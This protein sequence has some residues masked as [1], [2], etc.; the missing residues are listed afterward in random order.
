MKELN[1]IFPGWGSVKE[2]YLDNLKLKGKII[3]IQ[4]YDLEKIWKNLENTIKSYDIINI[5]GWSLG[6]LIAL[7]LLLGK[8][9]K[10]EEKKEIKKDIKNK[11]NRLILFAPTLKFTETTPKVIVK[12]MKKNLLR[13]KE[14]TLKEFIK[15]N[16]Y[17]ENNFLEYWEKYKE[18]IINLDTE[19]LL[20][21]LDILENW[22]LNYI[23]INY[24]I[25]L[26]IFL[27]IEDSI[28]INNNSNKVI[29]KFKKVKVH[30]LSNC[31]HNIIFEKK[32]EIIKILGVMYD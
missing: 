10:E 9:E 29:E 12:R 22:D 15:L 17:S 26:T 27:G 2:F 4:D 21:G 19:Y 23:G 28:I 24:E 25:L 13:N 14:K 1:I 20:E 18:R 6:S 8:E 16:F 5:I 11:I 32:D 3:V 30:K 31:G 7:K